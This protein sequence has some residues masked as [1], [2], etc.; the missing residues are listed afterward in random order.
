M[1]AF[2][3]GLVFALLSGADARLGD[4]TSAMP[5]CPPKD[6]TTVQNFDIE[7]FVK[8]RWYIQ[9]QMPVSY[10]PKSE[11]RCVYAEYTV[12]KKKTFWGYDVAVHNYAEDVAA[13]HKAHDSKSLIC[14]KIVDAKAGKLA[15]A[16]CFLPS[17][18]AGDYWVLDF[19]DKEGWALI[20]GGP[21]TV[22]T[23]GGCQTGKGIN[24]SGL[25]IFTRQQK[26]D[27][28][29]VQKVRTIAQGKGFDL[30]VLNDVDQTSCASNE[31]V[32]V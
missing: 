8:T 15:V 28:A 7:A 5:I 16:P 10:L 31:E 30:S 9:Q 32:V 26:T 29:V 1:T 11:N 6:F 3:K 14:A 13:P 19:N 25:W 22:A 12:E 27:D 24:G 2:T 21:P 4:N 23:A 17:V 20:S 18:T